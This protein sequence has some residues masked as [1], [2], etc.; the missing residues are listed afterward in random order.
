[1][2]ILILMKR[3]GFFESFAYRTVWDKVREK[4][5][6]QE[7]DL[8]QRMR[9]VEAVAEMLLRASDV[10]LDPSSKPGKTLKCNAAW[11]LCLEDSTNPE[12]PFADYINTLMDQIESLETPEGTRLVPNAN[13]V[14]DRLEDLFSYMARNDADLRRKCLRLLKEEGFQA[15]LTCAV[16]LYPYSEAP[17]VQAEG[18]LNGVILIPAWLT[19]EVDSF[20]PKV[21][22]EDEGPVVYDTVASEAP[23]MR[24]MSNGND[25]SLLEQTDEAPPAL[26][27]SNDEVNNKQEVKHRI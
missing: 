4:A 17:P 22:A 5:R 27:V 7:G 12:R 26:G 3:S 16:D 25:A 23:S 14:L 8:N 18:L 10:E 9:L 13:D 2:K 24:F 6:N 11:Q 15:M 20:M 21:V 19:E 1:M